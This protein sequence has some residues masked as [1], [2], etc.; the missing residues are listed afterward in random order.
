MTLRN[1]YLGDRDIERAAESVGQ[2]IIAPM[3]L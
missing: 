2:G 3:G 1:T